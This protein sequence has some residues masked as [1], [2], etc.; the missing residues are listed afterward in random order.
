MGFFR[1]VGLLLWKNWLL[2]KRKICV[3]IFEVLLPVGF[4]ILVL[5]I[6]LAV[7]AKEYPDPTYYPT[8]SLITDSLV[9]SPQIGFTPNTLDT[10]KVM[11]KVLKNINTMSHNSTYVKFP[12]DTEDDAVKYFRYNSSLMQMVVVF[13]DVSATSRLP[14]NIKFSIRPYTGS[15]RWRTELN[16]PVFQSNSPRKDTDEPLYE[17]RGVLMMQYLVGLAVTD[18]HRE[19]EGLPAANLTVYK[20]RMAYPHY[21]D[22]PM[23]LIIQNNLPLFIVLSFILSIIINTK[24]LVYEKERKLKESMKLMGLTSSVHWVSWFITYAVY[25]VPAMAIYAIIFSIKVSNAGSV[26]ANTDPSLFFVFLLCYSLAMISFCFMVSTFVQ[27]ANVGAAVAGVLFFGFFFPYFFMTQTYD[28]LTRN[29][30]LGASLLFNVAMSLGAN[31]IGIHEGTGEGAQWRNFYQPATVD[32]NLSLLACMIMLLVDTAIHL[33]ICWYLDNIRPGEYGIPKPFYFCFTKS[34]WCGSSQASDAVYQTENEHNRRFEKEPTNTHPGIQILNLKKTFGRKVAVAGTSLNLYEG[35]ITVLLGHNGA[36]KTTTMS[37]LTGFIPPTSGTAI[38]NGFD[39]RTNIAGVRGS[40]GLCPQHNILF[41]T[42]T[43][44]EHLLFFAKLK[45]YQSPTLEEEVIAM[46]KEVGLDTKIH[47]ASTNLSGGQKRKLSVGI[48]LIGGSKVVILDE[49]SSGMDPAARRQTWNVLQRARQG[50]TLVLST[51]YMDEADLLGDRIAIMA[52]GVVK[53]CGS[54]MFLKKLYGA[55]YHLV[56]VKLPHCNV[57][58]LTRYIQ[59]HVKTAELETVINSEVSYLLADSES[60]KFPTL[61]NGL[62]DNKDRLGISSFGTSATTMEE[63]FLKVGDSAVDEDSSI[64]TQDSDLKS[65]TKNG[66]LNPSFNTDKAGFEGTEN[67]GCHSPFSL[68]N[69]VDALKGYDDSIDMSTSDIMSF[70]KGFQKNTGFQLKKSRFWGLFVKKALHTWRNRVVTFVQLLLPVIFTIFGL[71]IDKAR[72]KGSDEPALTFSLKDFGSNYVPCGASDGNSKFRALYQSQFSG[73]QME[74]FSLAGG[75]TFD[76]YT[77]K[78]A[79]DLGTAT[80]NKRMIVG[81]GVID[82]ATDNLVVTAAYN[83][84]PYHAQPISVNF[85]MNTILQFFMN[86]SYSLQTSINPLPKDEEDKAKFDVTLALGAGFSVGLFIGFGMAFLTTMFIYFLIK[87]R[88]VGAKHMQVVSG[89][90]PLSYWIPTFIWDFINYIIPSLLLLIVFL[91][92]QQSA[93]LDDGRWGIVILVLVIYGWAVLPF[94]YA[95]QFAFQSPPSGVVVVIMLNIFSGIITTTAVFVLQIPSIGTESIADILDWV[96]AFIFPNYNMATCFIKLYTNYLNL[97]SCA[98]TQGLC[99]MGMVS[100]C[101]PKTCSKSVFCVLYQEDYMSVEKPGIGVYLILMAVQGAV[102]SVIVLLIEYHFFQR[103][104]YLIRGAPDS[105][106]EPLPF[107]HAASHVEDSDVAAERQRI[108]S[109]PASVMSATGTDSLLLVNL[110]KR[111]GTFVSVDHICVGVPEQECFGLLG[112]NGAG[113]TT[114]F[115]MLTGDVMVTGGNAYLKGSDVRSNIKEVQ[116]NMG[117]CPQFDALIDQ[118]TGRET[119]FMYARLRGVPEE[120]IPSVVNTLLDILMLRPHA[121]K[122]AG[123]YSGGNKRKLSTAIALIGDPPFIML[124]EPS[125]GMD[126]KARRQLWNVLSQ[127]RASGRTLVLTSHSMEECDALCTRIAIMVN[128]KFMCLGSPQ[129][130]KNKFGQGYTLIVQLGALPDGS[131]APNEPVID[132]ILEHFAGAKVFDDHQG[133]I[134][135]QVPDSN[136]RLAQVFSIMEDLKKNL[137]VSDYSVHQTTLEQVF[138]TFTRAQ[139]APKEETKR[140]ELAK[141]CCCCCIKGGCYKS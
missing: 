127:V 6:R 123:L 70:N 65:G 126:P 25:L 88:Q 11:D 113:K 135:F 12:F 92:Y 18:Y 34:Y 96:F 91:A 100:P 7:K 72:P 35:Q 121:D 38:V 89:V 50:R 1:Q 14:K 37:M 117:Y 133:Y 48:A 112:Q 64:S 9:N 101:C 86:S 28:T 99:A 87:E 51:H 67:G 46:A 129:H 60:S 80:F 93:Y 106:Q 19:V 141:I 79:G 47:T 2:Q 125:S 84:Q 122:L 108:N 33:I 77:L 26:L 104:W 61:F 136:V 128:G 95:L 110:Y 40:L 107:D 98:S 132:F 116:A 83:G 22:D 111:Y 20:Q 41:D 134:H 13:A 32:D 115:K 21:I 140:S 120:N 54:S 39:I 29:S 27:K 49:P 66:I 24:N 4:A 76:N 139:I 63:V 57:D 75:Y 10:N 31:V 137:N 62:D 138:L 74:N 114:T 109:S 45:G 97:K 119:L 124:D 78:R 103:I 55:G 71:A 118:M 102:F 73:S 131:T 17:S 56:V 59:T 69:K 5:L 36:G 43:V 85:L 44:R 30:K 94:M 68:T 130:L 23:I 15:A 82:S 42:M 90:G 3:S 58:E 53:C 81:M 8:K 52:E 16:F 105:G